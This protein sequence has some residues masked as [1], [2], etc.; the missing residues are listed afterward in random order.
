MQPPRVIKLLVFSDIVRTLPAVLAPLLTARLQICPWCYIGQREMDTAI[1]R[2]RDKPVQF[3]I[4]YRPYKLQP[5]LLEGQV[6]PK[7]EYYD[8]RFGPAK[9]ESIA[10]AV[11]KRAEEIGLD[12]KM[13]SGDIAQTT[14]AHRLLLKAWQLGG[15]RL[16]LPLLNYMFKAYFA[17]GVNMADE[18][19]LA[20]AAAEHTIMSEEEALAFLRSDECQAEVEQMMIDVR[21]KGVTGVPFVVIDSKWAVS[22]G[23]SADTYV[24]IFNKIAN[25]QVDKPA[26]PPHVPPAPTCDEDS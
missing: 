8:S 17:D 14:I 19:V 2:C 1:D 9:A 13:F 24:Q 12:I 21:K 22:G 20:K 18:E 7:K 25:A 6:I 16:Q 5:S 4:E 3:E 15:Q 11:E 26:S 10:F 23:Q